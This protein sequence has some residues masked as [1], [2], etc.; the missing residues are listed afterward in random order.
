MCEDGQLIITVCIAI[1]KKK[2]QLK[3][4][5]MS[6]RIR[7]VRA[8]AMNWWNRKQEMSFKLGGGGGGGGGETEA[9]L[10]ENNSY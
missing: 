7:C 2:I 9:F 8:V 10:V 3:K 1:R 4:M 6:G 5:S